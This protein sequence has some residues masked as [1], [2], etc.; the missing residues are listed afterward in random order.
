MRG[1]ND[2][3]GLGPNVSDGTAGVGPGT[4]VGG[5][6]GAIDGCLVGSSVVGLGI[7][8]G[9]THSPKTKAVGQCL[10]DFCCF[11]SWYVPTGQ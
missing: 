7:S 10:H 8:G 3:D 4:T 5:G 6:V 9:Q 11:K 1:T 2:G